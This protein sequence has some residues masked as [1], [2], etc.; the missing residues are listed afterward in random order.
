MY[1]PVNT[2]DVVKGSARSNGVFPSEFRIVG[3]APCCKSAENGP[4]QN[5]VL[6][7]IFRC[8]LYMILL[9]YCAIYLLFVTGFMQRSVTPI[10]SRI[11]ITGFDGQQQS[12][13]LNVTEAAGI[14]ENMQTAFISS[15]N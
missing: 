9:T 3:S 8:Y 11:H 14:V 6:A 7:K 2:W 13:N 5:E 12:D 10:V 4:Y 15:I 1:S